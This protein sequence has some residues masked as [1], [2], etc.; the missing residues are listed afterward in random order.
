M[1]NE[2]INKKDIW[3]PCFHKDFGGFESILPIWQQ[4]QCQFDTDWPS[5]HDFNQI[6]Q[7]WYWLKR[8]DEQ[9]QVRFIEQQSTMRY[10]NQIHQAGQVP[11]RLFHWHDFFNNMTWL[12]F[13]KTKWALI[14]KNVNTHHA[15]ENQRTPQQNLLAHFDECGI[16]LCSDKASIFESI[17]Q[18]QWKKLFWETKD[19]LSHC[20]P[21][22]I[23]H[24]ILEK[25]LAPYIGMTAKAILLEVR[26]DF[27]TLSTF[28]KHQYVDK[29]LEKYILSQAFPNSPQAL[30]PFPLLGWPFWH[31]ENRNEA[32]YENKNYFRTKRNKTANTLESAFYSE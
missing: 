12:N 21:I 15:I 4:F 7:N 16:V 29:A 26:E 25:A 31:P 9:Y 17:K 6:A 18:F 11:S 22:I 3:N 14:H 2:Q 20:F 32:F 10:E 24:G 28:D 30:H 27:F 5:I 19:L 1:F 8:I 13:P 23:G